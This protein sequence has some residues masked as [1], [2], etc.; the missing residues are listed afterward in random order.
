MW[1]G[2]RVSLVLGRISA[3]RR[4][5]FRTC[6]RSTRRANNSL[7]VTLSEELRGGQFRTLGLHPL[8][9]RAIEEVFRYDHMTLVQGQ[10]LPELLRDGASDA[11]VHAR[12]GTGKTLAYL[13]P[14]VEQVSR[15]PS[16]GVGVLVV[17]PTR[18]LALQITREAERLCSY[19]P[20]QVVPLIGGVNR[21]Q[22]KKMLQR[23]RPAVIV[24]TPGR[25]LEHFES[26]FQ[27][28]T[29]FDGLGLLVLD[30]CD[31]L[32]EMSGD[33]AELF[34]YLNPYH[35]RRTMLFSATMPQEVLDLVGT[36]CNRNYDFLDC[37][38]G[39]V[40]TQSSV[41]QRFV[42]CAPILALT[43]V[44]N[45]IV[46]EMTLNPRNHK[47]MV[48]FPTARL[49]HFAVHLFRER[50]KVNA[51]EIHG[52]RDGPSRM[53][54]QNKFAECVSGLLFTSGVS[55][56]G[57]DY[58][59]V[60]FVLQVGVPCGGHDQ[61]VHRVGRTARRGKNGRSLMVVL[62]AEEVAGRMEFAWSLPLTRHPHE[63]MLFHDEGT[64]ATSLAD[65]AWTSKL[66]TASADGAFSSLLKYY[67]M[68]MELDP[69]T[70]V[71][72][73]SEFML[74]CGVEEPPEISLSRATELGLQHCAQLRVS[75]SD[76]SDERCDEIEP[77]LAEHPGRSRSVG[78]RVRAK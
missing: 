65:A 50:L 13:I 53:V 75:A 37:V 68:T 28:Q 74:G 19:H 57:M 43:V 16:P 23:R 69:D 30:E 44:F 70:A 62:D 35:T 42:V 2:A 9:L 29:L 40:A 31:R 76:R 27:F 39:G 25:L 1:T 34:R 38:G 6:V 58:H 24:G 59:D 47:I 32:V 12:T 61:Y 21:H 73:S 4:T 46:E 8:S 72:V 7:S 41:E 77:S 52:R 55:E 63:A 45:A 18:E 64:V 14:A 15:Q 71:R 20:H 49:T 33:V 54:A 67:R 56:R 5:L 36:V 26:T 66:L 22:D 48:F 17:S 10:V 60:T 11:V 3:Q 78:R 51:H